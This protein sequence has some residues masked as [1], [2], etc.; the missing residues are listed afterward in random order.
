[1]NDTPF[2]SANEPLHKKKEIAQHFRVTERT[3][4]SWVDQ[5]RIPVIRLSKRCLRFRL[6]D[7]LAKFKAN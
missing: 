6:S 4:Q 2:S 7:V 5:R 1:M 3:V